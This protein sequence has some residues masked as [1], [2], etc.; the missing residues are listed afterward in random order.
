MVEQNRSASRAWASNSLLPHRV[1]H[2]VPAICERATENVAAIYNQAGDDY[3][4]YADGDPTQLFAFDGMHA[5]ADRHVWALLETKLAALRASGA[6]SVSFLD[7]GCG[8]G[9]WLR[10]LV[11]RART[12][13]FTTITARGFDIAQ[14]QIQRARL[15]AR[16]LS[17]LPGVNFTFDV[18]DLTGRLPEAD[19][20]VDITLCLY[21][22]L[23]HL[24]VASLTDIST[25]IA[26]VTSGYFITTVR[27]IG[28]TPTAFVDSIERVRQLNLD[29]VRNR[30]EIEFCDGRHMA[31][32][33]RLFTASELRSHFAIHFD[34][35]DLRG[36]DLF[37]SRFVPDPRW[38]PACSRGDHQLFDELARLEEAYATSSEFM[39]RGA[40]LLLV[41]RCRGA[42]APSASVVVPTYRPADVGIT[43]I[44]RVQMS[45]RPA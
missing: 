36:L 7:A 42:A 38:N 43:A 45:R 28:S 3:V 21:S 9:T 22:V 25:E 44:S 39:D 33:F 12:L 35:E 17:S 4:A 37:H 26:R 27:S 10:R 1:G 8:P 29:H 34:I 14:A 30:C 5:Y 18:A 6:S 16:N 19:A 11:T 32:S 15:L 13:G 40:H 24:P 2:S 20:S 41:A 31:F 23:S